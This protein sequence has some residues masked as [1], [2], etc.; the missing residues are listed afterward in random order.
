VTPPNKRALL[1]GAAHYEHNNQWPNLRTPHADVEAMARILG[2]PQC[3]FFVTPMV[4]P[5]KQQLEI[6]ISKLFRS[7]GGEDTVIFYYSGHGKIAQEGG[8]RLCVRE[9]EDGELLDA[10]AVA[11]PYIKNAID[12]TRAKRVILVFH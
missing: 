10:T 1:V 2:A 6:E 12:H 4:D 11:V 3:G 7:A 9:T 5:S 8:L